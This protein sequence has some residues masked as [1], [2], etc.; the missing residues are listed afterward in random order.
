MSFRICYALLISLAGCAAFAV[1][2]GGGG[3]EATEAPSFDRE[4]VL[5]EE[6]PPPPPEP[7]ES[8]GHGIALEERS[9]VRVEPNTGARAIGL[10][11]TGARF[12][13]TQRREVDGKIWWKLRG[14]G[15]VIDDEV[16]VRDEEPTISFI[17][18]QPDRSSGMPYPIGR[19]VTSDGVPVFRRPPRQGQDTGPLVVRRLQ[20]GYFFTVD[21]IINIYQQE[22]YRGTRY[23]WIPRAGTTTVRAP[24]FHGIEVDENTAIPFLWV[25]D[26]TARVCTA[27]NG[28]NNPPTGCESVPR[29]SRLTYAATEQA[30]GQWYR[31]NDGKY[32]ASLQ[33]SRVDRVDRPEGIYAN[34][35]WVHVDLLNQFAALYEGDRMTYVTLISSGD[36]DHPTPTGL[37]RVE[38]KH[39]SATMDNEDNLSSAFFIQDVPWVMYFRGSY[40]LH[41]AFWHDRFGLRTSHGCV[42]LAPDDA[43]R[44]FEFADAPDIPDNFHAVFTPPDTRS[45]AVYLT[46]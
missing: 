9:F 13:P 14:S 39:V 26:P 18:R 38:S 42:N 29:H 12:D 16:R 4:A 7:E 11:R 8:V 17:P 3:A 33:V 10:L 45:T 1:G 22:L 23:W 31:T 30:G 35:R 2:C 6:P 27:L 25:T 40:A 41:G 34:E 15:W 32:I 46:R 24:D 19:V 43:R 28:A 36:D 5:P 37:F 20:E 44:F 21:R